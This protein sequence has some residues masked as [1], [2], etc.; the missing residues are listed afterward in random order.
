M[1]TSS[2]THLPSRDRSAAAEWFVRLRAETC[3]ASQRA[4]FEAWMAA[5]LQHRLAYAEV[6]AV[7]FAAEQTAD[8]IRFSVAPAVHSRRVAVRWAAAVLSLGLIWFL[9][10]DRWWDDARA[11]WVSA[12]GEMR[13]LALSDGT[14]LWLAADSAVSQDFDDNRRRLELHRGAVYVQVVSDPAR[15][16]VIE[17]G[18]LSATALGTRYLVSRYGADRVE[19][20]EG[21]V[22]VAHPR[23]RTELVAGE[24]LDCLAD[25][26]RQQ[27]VSTADVATWRN[28][29]LR[30]ENARLADVIDVLRSHMSRR[31]IVL[32]SPDV[33]P[34]I[35]A[36]IPG[37]DAESALRSLC[38]RHGL[39]LQQWGSWL[40]VRA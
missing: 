3:D 35:T 25:G 23:A 6:A 12:R 32:G 14:R 33:Q 22:A 11:D 37:E 18:T 4:A 9:P 5:D 39:T 21:R 13:E 19:V 40:I 38:Q 26:C 17:A 20:E 2:P 36:L 34:R 31:V 29:M 24:V 1:T 30:F 16:F 27:S 10:V 7:A 8:G 28:G 15:P